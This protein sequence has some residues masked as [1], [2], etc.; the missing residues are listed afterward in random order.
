[1][2]VQ[3]ID[4]QIKIIFM[5]FNTDEFNH[6]IKHRRSINTN[7]FTGELVEDHIINQMLEN[8]VWAPTHKL[9]EPWRFMVFTGKGLKKLAH[10]QADLYKKIHEKTGK[11]KEEK[12]QT[13]LKKPL[14]ASHVIAIG[15]KRDEKNQIPEIEEIEA[16]ACAVQNMSLTATA[17]GV[18]CYWGSGGIT[19][20][21]E[22][23]EFF[24]LNENDKFL[25]FLFVGV[26]KVWPIIKK[27]STDNK[28]IWIG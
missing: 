19:Y 25:G 20:A 3:N 10:F 17:Y 6:L 15:M 26:A 14:L 4:I 23:K 2:H 22:A 28:V 11:F 24:N 9:T 13:L 18:G 12:Y 8:A 7:M 27:R 21:E 16:V 5:K 1:M